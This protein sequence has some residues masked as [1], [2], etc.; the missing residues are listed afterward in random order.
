MTP[1]WDGLKESSEVMEAC[2][3]NMPR[4]FSHVPKLTTVEKHEA[5]FVYEQA[6]LVH[7]PLLTRALKTYVLS[8]I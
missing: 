5:E 6:R 7:C 2:G 4:T 3:T 1:L 8:K